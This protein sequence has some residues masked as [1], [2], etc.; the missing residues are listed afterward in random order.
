MFETF[1]LFFFFFSV[2]F[3]LLL[4]SSPSPRTRCSCAGLPGR[5]PP[6][7]SW[8]STPWWSCWPW[9]HPKVGG[10]TFTLSHF[11]GVFN[12]KPL[13]TE[14]EN[15]QNIQ[16]EI[17]N[18]NQNTNTER[19]VL[20]LIHMCEECEV[21]LGIRKISVVTKESTLLWQQ[22]PPPPPTPP[23]PQARATSTPCWTSGSPTRS[24]SPRPS[25]WTRRRRRCCCPTGW[26]CAWSA[27][28]W[29]GWWTPRYRTWS[30][31]SCCS[32]C[33]P[34]ASPCPAWASCCSTW[35]RP[36]PT[37]R[38]RWSRT[39]WTSVSGPP[40][41]HPSFL[42]SY[43]LMFSLCLCVCLSVSNF[44]WA[45]E[46]CPP[47]WTLKIYSILLL[48]L[49]YRWDICWGLEQSIAGEIYGIFLLNIKLPVYSFLGWAKTQ[50]FSIH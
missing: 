15:A 33:S 12:R 29:G 19:L 44:W 4:F 48:L 11:S 6:C 50:R 20:K 26:S 31:S 3:S 39:S 9:D 7:T 45:K 49:I 46:R 8:W 21:A 28:R 37:T 17:H 30:P 13:T 43:I 5:P 36:C 10:V 14:A 2:L 34:S 16:S 24:P 23:A 35:T 40:P 42:F 32:S 18:N 41:P 1:F 47:W 22:S 27:R 38:R 25:W